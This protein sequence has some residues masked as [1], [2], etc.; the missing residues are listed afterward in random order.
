MKDATVSSFATRKIH[1]AYSAA[2]NFISPPGVIED[3][4]ELCPS[5]VLN[6]TKETIEYALEN[7]FYNSKSGA[8]DKIEHLPALS[9]KF[10]N[11]RVVGDQG[12]IYLPNGQLVAVCPE[13]CRIRRDKVRRPVPGM[14][15]RIETPVFHLTGN[16]HES[17]GHFVIQHLPRLMAVR[18]RLLHDRSAKLLL[19][20]GHRGWQQFYLEKL[21]FEPDCLLEGTPGTLS[22]DNLEYVPFFHGKE[23]LVCSSIY[24]EMQQ[25]FV[26]GKTIKKDRFIF[27]SRKGVAHRALANEGDVFEEC[28][29]LW[30]K[31][32]RVDLYDYNSH[33][34]I[35]LFQSARVVF[36]PHGQAFTNMIYSKGALAI[37]IRP[38]SEIKGWSASFRNLAIQVGNEAVVLTAGVEGWKNKDNW[39]YSISRLKNQLS[40]LGVLLP[41]KYR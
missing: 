5:V 22:I 37:I 17:H 25:L 24:R 34:Q 28:R 21:G 13:V 31:L 14:A 1:D 30:P 36:G 39:I 8:M 26:S 2:V 15:R 20:P 10:D 38:D 27:L 35:E 3:R 11:V 40:R 33:E 18:E 19:A 6:G 29:R 4:D 23:N 7:R 12:Y 9:Y 41:P 16:N 32:E